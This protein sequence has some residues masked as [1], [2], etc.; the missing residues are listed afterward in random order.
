M[1]GQ[2]APRKEAQVWAAPRTCIR[3]Q[4]IGAHQQRTE[5]CVGGVV[6]LER[7]KS[8]F[9]ELL[10]LRRDMPFSALYRF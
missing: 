9:V 5:L 4:R 6:M 8:I 2:L 10:G 1:R 7:G 3:V